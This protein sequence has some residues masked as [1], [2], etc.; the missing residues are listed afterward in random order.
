MLA[1]SFFKT[2]S[3]VSYLKFSNLFPTGSKIKT[4]FLFFESISSNNIFNMKCQDCIAVPLTSVIKNESYS[5]IINQ[6]DL[7]SGRLIRQSRA[8]I[9]KLFAVNKS[10]IT[11]SVGKINDETFSRIR[12]EL[13]EIF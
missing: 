13:N 2:F 9:D 7:E 3:T 8:R 1:C 4:G 10:L 11:R 6:D 5:L 12:K